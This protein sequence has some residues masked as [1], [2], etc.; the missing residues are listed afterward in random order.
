MARAL[1]PFRLAALTVS[2]CLT[3]FGC[4]EATG[5]L[6]AEGDELT[7]AEA[8][9]VEHEVTRIPIENFVVDDP[10]VGELVTYDGFI[11]FIFHEGNNRG[12]DPDFFQHL[13]S[14]SLLKLSGVGL[15]TGARYQVNRPSTFRVQAEDLEEPFP[16]TWNVVTKTLVT[17]EGDGVVSL[18]VLK[19]TL[20]I[21]ADD[22]VRVDRF[23][24]TSECP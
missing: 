5:P 21:D 15:T 10:C 6:A 24:V 19:F 17:R 23:E 12:L 13:V 1:I 4:D 7:P 20:V 11:Q 16:L 14:N 18:F 2:V 8:A 9:D 3:A 22:Q